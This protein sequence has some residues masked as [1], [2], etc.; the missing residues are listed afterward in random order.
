MRLEIE[1]VTERA[2]TVAGQVGEAHNQV[3]GISIIGV[4]ADVESERDGLDGGTAGV[5][6]CCPADVGAALG[7]KD[8]GAVCH[9]AVVVCVCPVDADREADAAGNEGRDG[10]RGGG[11]GG[12][13]HHG[14][15][16]GG[17]GGE[18]H[19]GGCGG[20][21][22]GEGHHGGCGGGVRGE[23]AGGEGHNGGWG[24]GGFD[25]VGCAGFGA[26]ILT[27]E[28]VGAVGVGLVDLE[29]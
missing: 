6:D 19:H 29:C 4:L 15:C 24:G 26:R 25:C 10:G 20:G 7:A 1:L 12:E 21:V 22:G 5:G 13:G 3:L 17:V 8:G 28:A 27:A 16:G 18:G 14:G 9:C 11:V 23:R 2:R